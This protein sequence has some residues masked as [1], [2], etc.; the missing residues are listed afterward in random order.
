[1]IVSL[2]LQKTGDFV[3]AEA[4]VKEGTNVVAIA[5]RGGE[6]FVYM[7]D[8]GE[9]NPYKSEDRRIIKR[10][11]KFS[12]LTENPDSIE[13]LAENNGEKDRKVIGVAKPL[14][15]SQASQ[16]ATKFSNVGLLERT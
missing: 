10:D 14:G 6:E 12:I 15:W 4:T 8:G 5:R 7:E 11:N 16:R 2:G 13:F 3:V 9:D 1:M